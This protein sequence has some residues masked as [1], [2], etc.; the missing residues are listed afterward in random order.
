MGPSKGAEP[1]VEPA[2]AGWRCRFCGTANGPAAADC[3]SCHAAR[4]AAAVPVEGPPAAAWV[5]QAP[6]PRARARALAGIA[7]VSAVLGAA[8]VYLLRR[9]TAETVTVAGFEWERTVEIEEK[10][11]V[12]EEAWQEE[13][14]EDARIIA[15]RSQVRGTERRQVGTRDGKPVYAERPVRGQRVAYDVDKWSVVRTLRASGKDRSP[16]WPDI[17]LNLGEREGPRGETYVVV[18]QGRVRYRVKVPRER[19]QEMRQGQIG[20]AVIGKDGALLELR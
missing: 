18:L 15:R 3:R 13:V 2:E 12:R 11:T 1:A 10:Q 14:P 9:P 7:L 16:R 4:T 5:R 20:S 8:T 6:R 17:R 19:W